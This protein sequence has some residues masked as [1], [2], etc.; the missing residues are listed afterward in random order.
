MI[1]F[2]VSHS[3]FFEYII[4]TLKCQSTT[5]FRITFSVNFWYFTESVKK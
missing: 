1:T 4:Q 3:Q 2:A 5:N